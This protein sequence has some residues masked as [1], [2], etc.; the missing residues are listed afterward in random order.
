MCVGSTPLVAGFPTSLTT[1]SMPTLSWYKLNTDGAHMELD[2]YASCGGWFRIQIGFGNLEALGIIQATLP[3]EW[4]PCIVSH[5]FEMKK[6]DWS[7]VFKYVRR[8]GNS[9]ADKLAKLALGT[10]L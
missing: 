9:L 3:R 2:A 7:V 10:D 6:R 1:W 8:E 4:A 5:I